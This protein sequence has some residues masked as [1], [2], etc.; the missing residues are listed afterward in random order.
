MPPT[1][2]ILTARN[3]GVRNLELYNAMA[4][5]MALDEQVEVHA[6]DLSNKSDLVADAVEEVLRRMGRTESNHKVTVKIL[7]VETDDG[8]PIESIFHIVVMFPGMYFSAHFVN[9]DERLGEV[10][11]ELYR[12]CL[13]HTHGGE[14]AI[15]TEHKRRYIK[16][17]QSLFDATKE[18]DHIQNGAGRLCMIPKITGM[19]PVIVHYMLKNKYD[20]L[21]QE[22]RQECADSLDR[23]HHQFTEVL[24]ALE[25]PAT[26]LEEG[27]HFATLFEEDFAN[28][29]F[30]RDAH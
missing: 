9:C 30:F 13:S 17:F 26:R 1:R 29:T 15:R 14:E 23:G 2:F 11:Q 22:V 8:D 19:Q 27:C 10:L 24:V 16:A 28:G 12:Q 3:G 20:L 5:A 25:S 4:M 7:V 18:K 21:L 6:L